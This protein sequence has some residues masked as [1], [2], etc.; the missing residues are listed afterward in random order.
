MSTCTRFRVGTLILSS[1]AAVAALGL[2]GR[3]AFLGTAHA[4]T[5][6]ERGFHRYSV[7]SIEV[8]ALCDGVWEKAHDPAFIKNASVDETKVALAAAG[9]PTDFVPIPFKPNL[10][11]TGGQV[12]LIDAGTGGQTGGPKAG[13]L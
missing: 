4:Q 13:C 10:L 8:T 5:T 1:A 7:G 2:N 9:L 3:V 11:K 6:M 12:T